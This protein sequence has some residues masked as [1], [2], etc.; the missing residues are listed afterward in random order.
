MK[1][2]LLF[3]ILLFPFS[4]ESQVVLTSSDA[5][6]VTSFNW[7]KT[8][9]LKYRGNPTDPVG[10][11][12]ECSL[13]AREAFCM[14]DA[15]H[16]SVG[17]EIIGESA[18]NKNMML[19][20]AE[21]ISISKDYCSFWEINRYNLPCPADYS[22]DQDFWYNLPGNMDFIYACWRLYEWTGDSSYINNPA[23]SN[24]FKLSMN[25][26]IDKWQLG[27]NNIM[28]RPR[29]MNSTISKRGIASYV[30][31]VSATVG[32]DLIAS[33]YQG[34]ISYSKIL[35]ATGANAEEI[36]KYENMSDKYAELIDKYWWN[37]SKNG[38][39]TYRK[40]DATYGRNEGEQY[41]LWFDIIKN[42]TRKRATINN[43]NNTKW[44]VETMSYYPIIFYNNGFYNEAY[45]YL[46]YLSNPATP[47]REYPEVGH[48]VIQGIINGTMG[49]NADA[50][51]NQ[52][53]T[54]PRQATPDAW[55]KA[56]S[57]P[58]FGN[59]ITVHHES[60]FKTT[61]S[62]NL[63][64]AIT[65][66]ASFKGSHQQIAIN[67]IAQTASSTVDGL[68]NPYSYVLTTIEPGATA[69]ATVVATDLTAPIANFSADKINI[70]V[71][72][73]I[74]FSNLST[75][76]IIQQT[77]SFTGTDIASAKAYSEH[78]KLQFENPGTF[79]V[80][81]TVGNTAGTSSKTMTIVVSPLKNLIS[82]S[83][84]KIISF[85]SEQDANEN[86]AKNCIDNNINTNWH[87]QWSPT[88]KAM[89]HD[90]KLSLSKSYLLNGFSYVPRQNGTNGTISKYEILISNDSLSWTKI[91]IGNWDNNN[92]EKYVT[93]NTVLAKYVMLNALSEVNNNQFASAAEIRFYG[94]PEESASTA[95]LFVENIKITC[96]NSKLNID[97]GYESNGN[98]EIYD[99]R[100]RS[101]G[102]YRLTENKSTINLYMSKGI[103]LINILTR[104]A[105]LIK[106][107]VLS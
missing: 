36:S 76:N 27:Y 45:E 23:I 87:T 82:R 99:V 19:K 85:D 44:N 3:L 21:N 34:C 104:K 40:T 51:N 50:F 73:S 60:N 12:Y 74:S 55:I 6:I 106:K 53:E 41:L 81:L 37:N 69:T 22:S 29:V 58:V 14:R 15:S 52:I 72:D 7:A 70:N 105:S 16:Q 107:I 86:A 39:N 43:L 95:A 79:T 78:L 92:K 2:K 84:Y 47:R 57:I 4:I 26:Y 90:I 1:T 48:S 96:T 59:T 65:W 102:K 25:E 30:E 9:S 11:W 18:E 54:M 88:I 13:P 100:G 31:S 56:Q 62:S 32:I 61:F 5:N 17:A 63:K 77:W 98:A 20:F 64:K 28:S 42:V 103:Y 49:I 97:L 8:T 68:G 35:K 101:L 46:I 80:K 38:Y 75:G 89:P 67:N 71:N 24:F 94:L 66:K 33:L 10:P 93:F 83:T 91:A